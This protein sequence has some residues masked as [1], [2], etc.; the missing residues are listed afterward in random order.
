MMSGM[1]SKENNFIDRDKAIELVKNTCS[2]IMLHCHN[3]YDKEVNDYVYDDIR[4]V[5]AILKCNKY[6][7]KA[8]REMN[9][10]VL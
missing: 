6:I 1:M 10:V 9:G 4:E 3:H 7:C 8:L 2:M 5:D